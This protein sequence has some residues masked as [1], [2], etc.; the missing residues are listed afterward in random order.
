MHLDVLIYIFTCFTAFKTAS[1]K[2]AVFP[3]HVEHP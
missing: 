2:G 3:T 1:D